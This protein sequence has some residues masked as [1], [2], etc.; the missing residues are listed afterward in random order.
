M[1][2]TEYIEVIGGREY[3]IP[4]DT[5]FK[6]W[7]K[8]EALL[9]DSRV[10]ENELVKLALNIIFPNCK[11]LDLQQA[12][13]FMLWFYRCGKDNSPHSEG[14][15]SML[16]SRMP[17]SFKHDFDLIAAAFLELY[18]IDLW[19]IEYLHWWKFR[20]LFS[21]LH[22]CKFTEI[23]G[24]R[25]ADLYE[26]KSDPRRDYIEKMQEIYALPI[27]ANE[28]RRIEAQRRWLNGE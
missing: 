12:V 3:H 19:E 1:L 10:P 5:D 27:S 8:L 23:C 26:I 13:N 22:D 6:R 4:V 7:I 20:A 17:Y 18:H 24:Y 14:G 15:T 9:T 2:P 11:P 21:A 28:I 25:Q 16:E